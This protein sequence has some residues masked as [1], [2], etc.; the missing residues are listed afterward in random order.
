MIK[1]I[2]GLIV[3]VIISAFGFAA[4]AADSKS[5]LEFQFT[6]GQAKW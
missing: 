1:T 6:I 5:Q 2:K 4:Y 3:A